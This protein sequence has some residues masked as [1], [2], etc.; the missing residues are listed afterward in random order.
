MEFL[1]FYGANS[2]PRLSV[3]FLTEF[4]TKSFFQPMKKRAA[5]V[6]A[7]PYQF[8]DFAI[9]PGDFIYT[10]TSTNESAVKGQVKSLIRAVRTFL[11]ERL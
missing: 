6:R 1:G 11:K 7:L 9:G 5:S 2:V 4:V 8:T 10:V 3:K